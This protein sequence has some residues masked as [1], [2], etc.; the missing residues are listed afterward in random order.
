MKIILVEWIIGWQ[1][2]SCT[3]RHDQRSQKSHPHPHPPIKYGLRSQENFE[4][5][6]YF[7][8]KL[9]GRALF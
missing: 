7:F 8:S 6:L 5:T 4:E 2:L 3:G 9:C 1:I